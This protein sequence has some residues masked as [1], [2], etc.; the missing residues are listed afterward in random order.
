[1]NRAHRVLIGL[2]VV[3]ALVIATI[4]FAGS[5]AAVRELAEQKGFG[6]FAPFFPIGIDAGIVVLLSL[7]L[8]MTHFRMSFPLL[9]QVAWVLTAATVV[10][11]AAVADDLLGMGMHAVIPLLFVVTVEAARHAIGRI[12]DITADKHMEGVRLTRWLL[13][14]IPTLRLWRMMKLWELR[15]YDDVVQLERERLIYRA[16][17]RAR[18][19]RGW[20]RKAPVEALMPLKLAKYGVPL[21]RTA[22]DGLAAAGITTPTRAVPPAG[23]HQQT[24]EDRAETPPAP[25][26]TAAAAEP[27]ATDTQQAAPAAPTRPASP[28]QDSAP[29]PPGPGRRPAAASPST[30]STRSTGHTVAAEEPGARP[31]SREPQPLT[32][33]TLDTSIPAPRPG[34]AHSTAS[35]EPS[36]SAPAPRPRPTDTANPALKNNGAHSAQAAVAPNL[37]VAP[38]DQPDTNPGLLK[39][40]RWLEESE[41]AGRKL[42]GSEVARRLGKAERTGRRALKDAQLTLQV[43]EWHHDAG[44]QGT[45]LT[46]EEVAARLGVEATAARRYLTD[47]RTLDTG[48]R[49]RHLRPVQGRSST[50]PTSSR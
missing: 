28:H 8:L 27:P 49:P 22:A 33:Q 19:G 46:A 32:R 18:Y 24:L 3:G 42:S 30:E 4:G 6:A 31:S 26:L 39:I 47:A 5:Y 16:R 23:D 50:S 17:L 35:T 10:F 44:K 41:K 11:N 2:V 9:R 45:D 14:P 36:D 21:S 12:A 34:P 13:A 25:E 43:L 20:R 40:I 29:P 38:K 7:D 37:N 48:R 15:R 1:M